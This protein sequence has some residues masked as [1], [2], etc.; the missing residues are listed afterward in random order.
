MNN[1][2]M[3]FSIERLGECHFPSPMARG[4]VT[5]DGWWKTNLLYY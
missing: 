4:Q 1:Q 3:D 2:D 5:G